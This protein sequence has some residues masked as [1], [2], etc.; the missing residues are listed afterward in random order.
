MKNWGNKPTGGYTLVEV[1]IGVFVFTMVI[2]A[3]L[4][5]V[6]KGFELVDNARHHNRVAQILQSEVEYLRTLPWDTIEGNTS[7]LRAEFHDRVNEQFQN[8]AYDVYVEGDPNW[9]FQ[10]GKSTRAKIVVGV[11]WKDRLGRE[12]SKSYITYFTEGGVS[13]YSTSAN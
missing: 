1:M 10:S 9:Q 6:S 4:V 11:T 13:D 8:D 12:H 7:Q 5:A 2:A 3:G